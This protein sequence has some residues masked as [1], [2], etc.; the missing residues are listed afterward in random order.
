MGWHPN[1]R[2]LNFTQPT[3]FT[4]IT[5]DPF[6]GYCYPIVVSGN[7]VVASFRIYKIRLQR[8]AGL[9]S[10]LGHSGL[11]AFAEAKYNEM[12]TGRGPNME[13]IPV[14]FGIRW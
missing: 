7:Q 10:R 5:R 4:T 12:F 8:G 1:K 2:G 3:T 9:E 13:C 6:F 14:T 11:K